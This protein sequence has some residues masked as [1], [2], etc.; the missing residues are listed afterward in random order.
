MDT[1]ESEKSDADVA[2][3]NDIDWV[4]GDDDI[5]W[6]AESLVTKR[7]S[8]S[9]NQSSGSS[10]GNDQES[11][12][13]DSSVECVAVKT[14]S[15]VCCSCSKYSSCKTNKC[16]CRSSG[17]LCGASC[18]CV[19]AKCSNRDVDKS[20]QSEMAEG[21]ADGSGSDKTLEQNRLLASHGAMLL[22]SALV[23]KPAETSEDGGSRRKPLSDIGNTTVYTHEKY[24]FGVLSFSESILELHIL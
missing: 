2:D 9:K 16:Q 10:S 5:D 8:K 14:T 24:P 15:E 20:L 7:N 11:L 1:S 3:D 19:S 12:K 18:G 17:E 21:I 6:A 23:E 22:E 13:K 4:A